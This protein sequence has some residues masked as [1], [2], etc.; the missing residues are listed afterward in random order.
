[1]YH[2]SESMVYMLEDMQRNASQMEQEVKMMLEQEG[3]AYGIELDRRKNARDLME[4][5]K[6]AIA[7][8]N[9]NDSTMTWAYIDES[10]C[11]Y[12]CAMPEDYAPYYPADQMIMEDMDMSIPAHMEDMP[13]PNM[14]MH[15][16]GTEHS[17]DG[18]DME[19]HHHEDGTMHNHEG[20]A[21]E[22][23]HED[24]YNGLPA[25]SEPEQS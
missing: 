2:H 8:K 18:G 4:E 10:Q 6:A 11:Q 5:L 16:D 21:E 22:H 9:H 20:G 15:E 7:E 14:H 17:H 1:M 13:D 3:R 12:D 19:H 24:P 23:T 25:G